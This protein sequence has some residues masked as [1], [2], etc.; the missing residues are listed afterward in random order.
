MLTMK[1]ITQH[2][3]C[4]KRFEFS[5]IGDL[6]YPK[7]ASYGGRLGFFGN[8]FAHFFACARKYSTLRIP[9]VRRCVTR[10]QCEVT[11][12]KHATLWR[13]TSPGT[14]AILVGVGCARGWSTLF[15]GLGNGVSLQ[16][17]P[18]TSS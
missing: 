9:T 11:G 17:L 12:K 18:L 6:H 13:L 2:G 10:Q 4:A 3:P 7:I 16:T 14:I 15:G 5:E 8:P 1:Y